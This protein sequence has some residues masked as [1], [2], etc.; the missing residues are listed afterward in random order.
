MN[1]HSDADDILFFKL[2]KQNTL[3]LW[4]MLMCNGKFKLKRKL[5]IKK[6]QNSKTK[7]IV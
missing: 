2:H 3:T 7:H 6:K 5:N 1:R 4:W